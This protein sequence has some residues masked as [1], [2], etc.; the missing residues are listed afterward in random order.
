MKKQRGFE[1][2]TALRDPQLLPKRATTGAAGYDLHCA[3][4]VILAPGEIKRLKTGV[5]AYMQPGE[6]LYVYD[7]SSNPVKRGIK[8]INSVGVIDRD[9]YN[10]DQ[11]EGQIM[12]Q[13]QN[14]TDHRVII[15]Y[16]QRILQAVFMPCLLADGDIAVNQRSGGFG[17]TD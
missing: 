6:V 13:L 10:N 2:L 8:L 9:Y 17:S 16:G 15:P 4:G 3:E 7:R 12:A 14:I 11:N 1:L 5:K